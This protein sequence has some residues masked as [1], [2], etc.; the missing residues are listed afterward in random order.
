MRGHRLFQLS[1]VA[2]TVVAY[3]FASSTRDGR[4]N[5]CGCSRNVPE[6]GICWQI[7]VKLHLTQPREDLLRS[8]AVTH[9]RTQ[10]GEQPQLYNVSLRRNNKQERSLCDILRAEHRGLESTGSTAEGT[11]SAR[12]ALGN[13]VTTSQ[14]TDGGCRGDSTHSRE[15][16]TSG[17]N[18]CT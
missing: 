15:I 11:K 6:T 7:S 8:R 2:T 9:G 3:I 14:L 10:Q 17:R 1:H 4:R 12:C 13:V 5:A 16:V 18:C